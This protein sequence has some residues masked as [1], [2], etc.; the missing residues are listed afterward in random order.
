ME[1]QEK[2]SCLLRADPAAVRSSSSRGNSTPNQ[3]VESSGP[4]AGRE[5]LK[6]EHP[7]YTDLP[8]IGR[9]RVDLITLCPLT[10]CRVQLGGGKV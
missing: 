1:T 2:W 7:H 3:S 6:I 8:H 4:V 10:S 5:Q 9:P